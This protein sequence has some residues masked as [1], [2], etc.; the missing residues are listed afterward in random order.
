MSEAKKTAAKSTPT[1]KAQPK[2]EAPITTASVKLVRDAYGAYF[3]GGRVGDKITVTRE[4]A[5]KMI[6][7]G[8][9]EIVK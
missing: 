8:H 7:S 9:A 4:L 3:I 6:Q 2:V 5:E 1:P